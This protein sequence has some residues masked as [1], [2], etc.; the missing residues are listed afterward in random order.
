M[1]RLSLNTSERKKRYEWQDDGAVETVEQGTGASLDLTKLK[2]HEK[3]EAE[4][5]NPDGG[6]KK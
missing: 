1:E 3:P 5:D 4:Q 6:V 2:L